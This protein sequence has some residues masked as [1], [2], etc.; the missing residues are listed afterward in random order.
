MPCASTFTAVKARSLSIAMIPTHHDS[1]VPPSKRLRGQ[2][3]RRV[4]RTS[5]IS[6][7]T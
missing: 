5:P 2:L 1:A 4:R 3:T 7:A 6:F